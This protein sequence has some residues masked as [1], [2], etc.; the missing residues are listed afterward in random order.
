MKTAISIPDEIFRRAEALAR[1]RKLSRSEL[2]LA[3]LTEYL[4]EQ[5]QDS[6]TSRLNELY[7]HQMSEVEPPLAHA[8][9]IAVGREEW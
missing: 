4:N 8:Q 2:Y 9:N 3:A 1:A 5:A 6:V 7:G